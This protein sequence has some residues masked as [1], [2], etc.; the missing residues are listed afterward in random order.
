MRPLPDER[1]LQVDRLETILAVANP[2]FGSI[3]NQ[4]HANLGSPL[5]SVYISQMFL[6]FLEILVSVSTRDGTREQGQ[7]ARLIV[8][9][10]PSLLSES[11][12]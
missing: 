9:H 2:V 1:V 6:F 12:Q 4:N 5:R 7:R 3:L 8:C 11:L 10:A